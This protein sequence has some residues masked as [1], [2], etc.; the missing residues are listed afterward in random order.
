MLML[1]L[2]VIHETMLIIWNFPDKICYYVIIH[3]Y[4]KPSTYKQNIRLALTTPSPQGYTKSIFSYNALEDYLK[5]QIV[6]KSQ[7]GHSHHLFLKIPS[8]SLQAP[9]L[10]CIQWI[11]RS[12]FMAKCWIIYL[13]HKIRTEEQP[14]IHTNFIS[15]RR[16]RVIPVR[17]L[18]SLHSKDFSLQSAL[19]PSSN[20]A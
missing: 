7:H 12:S 13:Q 19:Y 5:L 16:W 4:K 14:W 1:L 18:F 10:M 20:Q 2:H 8:K 11:W 9:D 6:S 3:K 15:S 17:C